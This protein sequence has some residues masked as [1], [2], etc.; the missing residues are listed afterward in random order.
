MK[1]LAKLFAFRSNS[2]YEKEWRLF[3]QWKKLWFFIH[4]FSS[5]PLHL[6]SRLNMLSNIH[7]LI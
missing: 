2:N 3:V 1:T 4:F 6:V 7:F 5:H